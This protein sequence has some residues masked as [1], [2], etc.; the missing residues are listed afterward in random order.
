MPASTTLHQLFASSRHREWIF[1]SLLPLFATFFLIGLQK[2]VE[3]RPAMVAGWCAIVL[4]GMACGYMANNLADLE[5]DR[6]AGKPDPLGDWSY[7]ARL[8]IALLFQIASV[9]LTGL[10]ADRWTVAAVA[11][12][13]L[14]G[15]LYS[16]P[17]RFKEWRWLG[18]IV[19]AIQFWTP[20]AAV[21][22]AARVFSPGAVCWLAI[23]F[24]YGL[25]ITIIHQVVDR[26]N[27]IKAGI[28][29]TVLTMSASAIQALLRVLLASEIILCISLI[30]LLMR[31]PGIKFTLPLL[32]LIPV[33]MYF[34]ERNGQK[35]QLDTYEYVPL[36]EFYE[37]IL[38]LMLGISLAVLDGAKA[39]WALP[40]LFVL[41]MMRH[42]GRFQM[43]GIVR[44]PSQ[45]IAK[46]P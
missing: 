31:E 27:D 33:N 7:R 40:C 39:R 16:F 17:P 23:L 36:S 34:R 11:G 6:R 14:L 32:L 35:I 4:L 43:S 46:Q 10:L 15:W 20:S 13:Q 18:P 26:E 25:R 41:L 5:V 3:L 22:I 28:V 38:P 30:V 37:S 8:G 1:G 24:V 45:A 9:L 19:A 21:M 12:F 42:S 44:N 2:P 29:T